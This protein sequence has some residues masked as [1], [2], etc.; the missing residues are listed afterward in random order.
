MPH[1]IHSG[2]KVDEPRQEEVKSFFFFFYGLIDQISNEFRQQLSC[3]LSLNR[4]I[5]TYEAWDVLY[6]TK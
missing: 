4:L 1:H 2:A 6:Q 5:I 3:L